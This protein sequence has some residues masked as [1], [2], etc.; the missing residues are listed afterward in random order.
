[1]HVARGSI[2]LNGQ[3]MPEGDGAR[4]RNGR[5]LNF[6]GGNAAEVLLFDLRPNELP[7]H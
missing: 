3:H 7:A 5:E 1:M 2:D 4:L 6:G